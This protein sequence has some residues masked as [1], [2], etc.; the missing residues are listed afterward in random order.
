VYS[1]S[2][3]RIRVLKIQKFFPA[4]PAWISHPCLV[5]RAKLKGGASIVIRFSFPF[6]A[7]APLWLRLIANR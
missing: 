2:N 5:T 1:F 3:R 7:P 4:R 6:T